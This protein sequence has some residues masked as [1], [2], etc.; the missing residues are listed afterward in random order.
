[1]C[2]GEKRTLTVPPHLGYGDSGTGPIPG[3]ST[4]HFTI[5]LIDIQKGKLKTLHPSIGIPGAGEL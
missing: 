5:H 2:K 3:K 1:M 4:L